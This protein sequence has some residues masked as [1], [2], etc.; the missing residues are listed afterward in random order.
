MTD[1]TPLAV[2]RR[3]EDLCAGFRARIDQL[4][5]TFADIDE[6]AGMAD[7]HTSKLL[8]PSQ[9]RRFGLKSLNKM[10]KHLK[11]EL[12][13]M[14]IPGELPR[15]TPRSRPAAVL[16]V[17][18]GRGKHLLMSKRFL[19]KIAG[20]GGDMRAHNLTPRRRRTIAR[21]AA[22]ARWAKSRA[23]TH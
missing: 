23:A 4:N 5:A 3:Y 7:R 1:A 14:P 21:K 15:I 9:I 10:M 18:V 19:R 17:N 13:M 22:R 16:A 2:V 6:L 11:V 12:W 8:S 20:R